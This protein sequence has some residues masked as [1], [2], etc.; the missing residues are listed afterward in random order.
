MKPSHSYLALAQPDV[1]SI[2]AEYPASIEP[3]P[4]DFFS[5]SYEPIQDTSS[6]TPSLSHFI[7][8]ANSLAVPSKP[9]RRTKCSGKC[10]RKIVKKPVDVS[11]ESQYASS[12]PVTLETPPDQPL[13]E[14]VVT[15]L[16]QKPSPS[17][18]VQESTREKLKVKLGSVL[19]SLDSIVSFWN[20]TPPPTLVRDSILKGSFNNFFVQQSFLGKSHHPPQ[21]RRQGVC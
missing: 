18:Q 12:K 6:S 9:K 17:N 15:H 3:A 10:K 5:S 21:K 8:A 13:I 2:P 1:A 20:S 19:S 14:P 11:I 16:L 7:D 4:L